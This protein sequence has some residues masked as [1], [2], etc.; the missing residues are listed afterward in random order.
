LW[1]AGVVA[2]PAAKWLGVEPDRAGRVK[3]LSDLSIPGSPNIF[4]IG[5]TAT[6]EQE[7]RPLPGVAPVA[8]QEGKYAARI[9]LDRVAGKP[10]T[11][12]FRYR[13]KGNLATVGRAFA[14]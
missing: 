1:A 13:D 14:L 2:S 7:G 9:I 6:L 4:V 12:A 5:D 8:L 3:V 10:E 11:K